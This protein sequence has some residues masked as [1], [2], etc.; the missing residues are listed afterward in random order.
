MEL[1]LG[2]DIGSVAATFV[3]IDAHGTLVHEGYALHHGDVRGTLRA[4]VASLDFSQIRAVAATASAAGTV[5]ATCSYDATVAAITAARHLHGSLDALL[6][7]G[8]EKFHL[9]R[10]APDGTYQE[11]RGSSPCAAGTGSFLDQQAR[12]LGLD[13]GAA[14]SRTA[15]AASGV[16]PKIASRCSV[17]AK[18]D[19]IHAQQQGYSLE[20][21]CNG[22]CQGLAANVVDTLF[23]GQTSPNGL[24][25]F[26]GGVSRN[27]AVKRHLEEL[28]ERPLVVDAH[29]H[30]YGALGAALILAGELERGTLESSRPGSIEELLRAANT[31]KQYMHPPLELL[32]SR[33]PDFS[34]GEH[35]LYQPREVRGAPPVELDLCRPLKQGDRLRAILGIDV[36][37]TST[38]AV[39]LDETCAR[40]ED[41][42]IAGF[43]TRT[44]GQP[45]IA[46]QGLFEAIDSFVH[47]RG[48]KLEITG[49]ATTGSGRKLIGAIV[50][51]DEIIDEIT[52]H[53]RA[54]YELDPEVDT[55]IEIGGQDAK[56][57]TLDAGRV[58]LSIM[59]N[60]CAAGT[61]SFIE[62]Q[63]IRLGCELTHCASRTRGRRSPL[64]SDCC[65]VFMERDINHYLASGYEVD[66]VLA[67]SLH[68]ICENYLRKVAREAAIGRK[69]CF[70][71]ATA[72]N[73][74]LVAAFEQRL[75]RPIFVSRHCHLTGALGAA[76]L[77]SEQR[78]GA[79]GFRGIGLY[80]DTIPV[81]DETCTLCKNHCKLKLADVRGARVAYGMLCGRDY[82]VDR[83]VSAN[84]SG[85]D[86]LKALRK[87]YA[88]GP[89]KPR[90]EVTIGLLASLALHE[91]LPMWMHFFSS[92]GV[93][94]VT[95]E[96]DKD[97]VSTGKRLAGAEF[98]APMAAFHGHVAKLATMADF[99]F[100]PFYLEDDDRPNRERRNFCYYTQ[101]AGSLAATIPDESI[102]SKLLTPV[103]KN[104]ENELTRVARIYDTLKPVLGEGLRRGE[105]DRA[106]REAVR[107]ARERKESLPELMKQARAAAPDDLAVVLLGRPYT[108]LSASMNKNIPEL[109]ASMGVRCFAQS[110][111]EV[112]QEDKAAIAPLLSTIHWAYPA[113]TLAAAET[114][115]RT[116]GLYPVIITSFKC[117]PD[118]CSLESMRRL[119]DRRGKPYLILQLDEH[120][121]QVGYET[122]IEAALRSFRNH[123]S[124]SPS[125]SGSLSL[126]RSE[127]AGVREGTAPANPEYAP[128]MDGRT[129]LIPCWDRYACTMMAANFR[130]EGVDARVLEETPL[131]IT[132][133]LQRNSGQCI[134]LNV[135]VEDFI[136]Y[137]TR[138][139]IDPARAA[140]WIHSSQMGCN[141]GAFPLVMQGLLETNGNGFEKSRVYV[142]QM[143]GKDISLRTIANQYRVF[144]CAGY[145]RRMGCRVRP[146]EVQAGE[147]DR[148]LEESLA[149]LTEA[150]EQGRN[151]LAAVRD[152]VSRFTAIETRPGKKPKVALFGDLYLRDNDVFN[153]SLIARIEAEGGEVITTPYS[154]Y[155]KLIADAYLRKWVREGKYKQAAEG[156][157]SLAAAR[158]LEKKLLREFERVIGPQPEVK[159]TNI[160][161][162]LAPYR[163]TTQHTGESFDNLLKIHH[164]IQTHPDVALFVQLSPA[165]CCPSLVT[166]AM[167]R[168]I[169]K[170]TGV[171]VVTIT[172]DGTRASKNDVIAPYLH[173]L[174]ERAGVNVGNTRSR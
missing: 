98:C 13:G 40:K 62:E 26:A 57:T 169:R 12:R 3:A 149:L 168:E 171:P 128:S 17:F 125:R 103:L 79:T 11:C 136:D 27:E 152:V 74:S 15:L 28:I 89:C 59:N 9:I 18:T 129:V 158:L 162:V 75:K 126:E 44:A 94:A 4:L 19:L 67:A 51:A 60:V 64:T 46:T 38:K 101:F 113:Q 155:A 88:H 166:E 106:Y 68:A 142:G 157:L 56:F 83:Y 73:R 77:L 163:V 148:V 7:V 134:P 122:R 25:V 121:S 85:F 29:S 92:L 24:I 45:L 159:K 170:N 108:V 174:R 124:L 81:H 112:S 87:H 167:T 43:Y 53:A 117:A 93:R 120:D 111:V 138:H 164:L 105:V 86:L 154:D 114:V 118:S 95:S 16:T 72:K 139:R 130:R 151:I 35:D 146:Y 135:I 48:L 172:Y 99:I 141:I 97:V 71:G 104:G 42:V 123:A 58:T 2:I 165:F 119:L 140:I 21:I 70:Q 10:F 144:L 84:K 5:V 91:D 116:P 156:Q 102:R 49:A 31:H 41:R 55:I 1:V 161:T 39:L 66:E 36:G 132:Q 110:M 115:A 137:V 127:R 90:F 52:A 65:T 69:I 100:A 54:A 173:F 61:G 147:T 82:E 160:S 30:V 33:Y 20:A 133:A 47:A 37:S 150:F 50:G 32:T 107:F 14:I 143:T 153:Q 145:L 23:G 109:F 63:A 22:L 131:L 96:G 80:R 76:L 8:G 34:E 6:I 78:T